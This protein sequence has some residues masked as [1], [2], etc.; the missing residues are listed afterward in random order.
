MYVEEGD[1]SCWLENGVNW[2]VRL[3]W[4]EGDLHPRASLW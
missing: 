4:E 2:V 3:N 1:C